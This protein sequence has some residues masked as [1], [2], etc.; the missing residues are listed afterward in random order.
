MEE[1]V[2]YIEKIGFVRRDSA[3]FPEDEA[4]WKR[5]YQIIGGGKIIELFVGKTYCRVI[6]TDSPEFVSFESYVMKNPRK[7]KTEFYN[8]VYSSVRGSK[9]ISVEPACKKILSF[10]H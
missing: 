7:P 8:H 6:E 4:A 10:A 5:S 1:I 9:R 2:T 3:S